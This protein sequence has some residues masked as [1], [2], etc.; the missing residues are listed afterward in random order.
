MLTTDAIVGGVHFLPD[1]P[2]ETV[3]RKALRVNLSDLAAKGANPAGFL[4]TLALPEGFGEA[5]LSRFASGLRS[6]CELFACPLFGGDT[7]RTPG[8]LWLSITAFGTLPRGTMVQA[9]R[10]EAGRPRRRDRHDRRRR[11]RPA[12]VARAG[13]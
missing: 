1:D 13:R 4:L 8:P 5:W 12:V 3:A 2:P 6:D 11:A 7:V 10:S 9:R